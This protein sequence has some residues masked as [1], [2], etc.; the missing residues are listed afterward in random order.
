MCMTATGS[1]QA[2]IKHLLAERRARA[3]LSHD[4]Y[5]RENAKIIR[6]VHM[7]MMRCVRKFHHYW[8]R[9]TD[10]DLSDVC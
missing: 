8:P 6:T 10:V 2:K 7:E 5:V 4:P 1:L 9:V 3:V